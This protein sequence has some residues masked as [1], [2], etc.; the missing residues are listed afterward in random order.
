MATKQFKSEKVNAIKAKIEKAQVAVIT[1]YQ[2]LTVEEITKLR[3]ELQKENGDYMVTKNTLT[4]VAIEGT[5]YAVMADLM[6]GPIAIAFGY[7]DQ[8]SPAKVVSNFIK[9]TKKAK[10]LVQ[11]LTVN[12]CQLMKLKRWL[13][14]LQKK[15]FM[16]KCLV[17]STHLLPV[18]RLVS[19]QLWHRSLELWQLLEIKKK[20]LRFS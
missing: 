4:K 9:T 17:L 13:T 2:G 1:E 8:V 16:Q 18:L 6:K 14:F 3:R 12:Y 20:Q 10:L 11:C 7:E 15:N 5:D 19:T